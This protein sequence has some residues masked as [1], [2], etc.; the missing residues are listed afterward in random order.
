MADLDSQ[1]KRMNG[2]AFRTG[3]RVLPL[4]DG[5]MDQFD[6]QF[7]ARAYLGILAG[8]LAFEQVPSSHQSM[9]QQA[10]RAI[11]DSM[12]TYNE[13]MMLAIKAYFSGSADGDANELLGKWLADKLS[14]TGSL[15][16]LM[17]KA[18][19]SKGKS[20]WDDLDGQDIYELLQ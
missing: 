12:G 17:T 19:Q 1:I 3:R 6:R 20:R 8:E 14:T 5:S 9:R 18:A 4:A 15:A 16:E 11:A 2:V 13:D 10:F 7:L